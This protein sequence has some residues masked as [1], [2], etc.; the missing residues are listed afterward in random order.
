MR[1]EYQSTEYMFM[2]WFNEQ[3]R[4]EFNFE[5]KYWGRINEEEHFSLTTLSMSCRSCCW[6]ELQRL[7]GSSLWFMN[8]Y[9]INWEMEL[10]SGD[11][12]CFYQ[13]KKERYGIQNVVTLTSMSIRFAFLHSSADK[14]LR[15]EEF[16]SDLLSAKMNFVLRESNV[17]PYFSATNKTRTKIVCSSHDR[18]E[19]WKYFWKQNKCSTFSGHQGSLTNVARNAFQRDWNHSQSFTKF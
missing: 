1:A 2:D 11:G 3:L 19:I 7:S 14:C 17:D 12:G 5:A 10:V 4:F 6:N 18:F 13:W 15:V 9:S 16:F 8:I